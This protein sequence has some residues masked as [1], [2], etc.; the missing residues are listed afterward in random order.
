MFWGPILNVHSIFDKKLEIYFF[1]H[2]ILQPLAFLNGSKKNAS[3][4]RNR[5]IMA[6]V[7]DFVYRTTARTYRTI[8]LSHS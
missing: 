8:R 4:N 7:F 3:S 2:R 5:M 1:P 6:A